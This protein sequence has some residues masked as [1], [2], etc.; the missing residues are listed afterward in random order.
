LEVPPSEVLRSIFVDTNV[1]DPRM[2]EKLVADFG[3]DHVLMGT[4]YPFDMGT[5]D[6]LGFLASADLRDDERDLVMGA[7]AVKL[8]D[9]K[10]AT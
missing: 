7:N 1:F 9:I 5:V 4:D 6:P 10:V 8:F 2:V 3:A